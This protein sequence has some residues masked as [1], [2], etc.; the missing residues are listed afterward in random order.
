MHLSVQ[1]T[2]QEKL[3][4]LQPEGRVFSL[5]PPHFSAASLFCTGGLEAGNGCGGISLTTEDTGQPYCV[6]PATVQTFESV[7]SPHEL[8]DP[9]G[10]AV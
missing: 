2:E 7:P 10:L 1:Q 4:E 8:T 5:S 9:S 6:G 3:Y